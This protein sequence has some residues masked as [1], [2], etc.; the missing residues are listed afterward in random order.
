MI[1]GKPN[2][3]AAVA[4]LR[5]S[6]QQ[7]AR[8]ARSLPP[9]QQHQGAAGRVRRPVSDVREWRDDSVFSTC[10]AGPEY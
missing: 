6:Q 10:G 8:R 1:E 2:S 4:G 7:R 3:P 9:P 5:T